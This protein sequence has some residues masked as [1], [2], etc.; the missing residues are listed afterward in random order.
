MPKDNDHVVGF[1][2]TECGAEHLYTPYVHAHWD[3]DVTHTCRSCAAQHV[4]IRGVAV[5]AD[6]NAPASLLYAEAQDT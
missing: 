5:N 4:V 6:T 1:R 2:C 3:C